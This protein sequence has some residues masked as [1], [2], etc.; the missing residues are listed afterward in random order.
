MENTDNDLE[1]G[2]KYDIRKERLAKAAQNSVAGTANEEFRDSIATVDEKGKRI[3]IYPKKPSGRYHNWRIV[4]TIVLLTIL[5]AGPFIKI[6]G[7]PFFL[8]NIFARKFVIF[9]QAFWPQDFFLLA[10]VAITFFVFIILFTVVFGRVWCGWMCPQTLFMEMVFRKIEYWIEGDA[11]AQRRLS[12]EPWT[13]SK[14]FKKTAKHF[15]F[16]TISVAIAHTVMAYI[17]GI[18]DTISIVSHSPGENISGF[19]GLVAFTAIFYG[20]YA[21]FREQACIAVCPYG[22]LQSVL[23]TKESIVVAYDWL[24]GEPRSHRKKNDAQVNS[25]DC[26]DCHLCVHVCPTGIDIRNG[27]QLECVN[28]TACIDACD[29]VMIKIGKPKG[30]IRFASYS[31]IT[32]GISKI[33]NARVIGYSVILVALTGFLGFALITRS[34]VETT[35]LKVP[36][37]LY[38]RESG[39]ITNLYNIELVNKTF[40]D[41]D[42]DIKIESP[43]FAEL[44]KAD[45][46]PVVIPAEGF[47]K[48]IYFIKIPDTEVLNARTVVKLG[49]YQKERLIETVSVKFIGPVSKSSDA[50]R[51]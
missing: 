46:K 7:Q 20:I 49:V 39:Y 11:P 1:G 3:W 21:K 16:L 18:E 47:T 23:L 31:S 51:K 4:V 33:I 22:R 24:R 17:I 29:D 25:G 38:Q 36:G 15:I 13:V 6:E 8:F 30:L 12:K 19:I 40:D 14:I 10:V 32:N 48:G 42:V 35:V 27:T 9:G 28:C 50:K 37:T 34:E 5:F 26:I 2:I 45:G 44:V 43:A 41:I